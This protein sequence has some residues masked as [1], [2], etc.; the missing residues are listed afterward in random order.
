MSLEQFLL[1]FAV[2]H[3]LLGAAAVAMFSRDGR[4]A[5]AIGTVVS[6]ITLTLTVFLAARLDANQFQLQ[7]ITSVDWVSA[8]GIRYAIGLDGTNAWLVILTALMTLVAVST[9]REDTKNLKGFF[10]LIFALQ[11]AMLGAFTSL[12]LVLFFT[13]FELTLLPMYFLI[14]F[15]GNGNARKTAAKFLIFTFAGSVFT[16]IG[17]AGLAITHRNVTGSLEFGL[18]ELQSMVASGKLWVGA[19]GQTILFWLFALGFLVK[20][21]C[22]PFHSWIG[23]TY[24]DSP[25]AGPILSSAMVKLGSYGL[26][27]FCL[28]LFPEAA[29]S[30]APILMG[31]A[32]V[33]ILYGAIAAIAQTDMRRLMGYSTLSHMGFV[34]LG[35]FSLSYVGMVGAAFQQLAHGVTTAILVILIW[36]L[37]E[38]YG[39]A[40]LDAFGGLKAKMPLFSLLFFLGLL[41]NVGLPGTMGFIGEFTALMGAFESGMRGTFGIS[42]GFA[43]AAGAGV[44]LAAVY[45]LVMYQ[46]VF[47]GPERLQ[48]GPDWTD[49]RPKAMVPVF[50]LIGLMFV[51]GLYS[52]VFTA[53]TEASTQ[54][55]RLMAVSLP[56]QRPDLA[57]PDQKIELAISEQQGS[58]IDTRTGT[59]ITP[60]RLRGYVVA[61]VPTVAEVNP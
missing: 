16:L 31:L 42:V 37:F 14:N 4:Q 35:I 19:D 39:T 34:L 15:W 53:P 12:D 47:Y 44:V 6:V 57:N 48:E 29:Q 49:I 22:F 36:Q 28:P 61:P 17:I 13:F 3:P 41:G 23:D 33:S 21:P 7:F 2:F 32:T 25:K 58:L 8:L 24:E 46:K 18:I 40:K 10:A 51:G 20:S 30:Q 9:T 45:L 11:T 59:V 38:Q 50:G 27:R 43:A 52:T 5:K 54:A 56:T 1:N 55:I 26:L 60:G